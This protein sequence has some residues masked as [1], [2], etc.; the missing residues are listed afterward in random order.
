M[1][2]A[3]AAE[4]VALGL[5][6]K[7]VDKSLFQ[8]SIC[9]LNSLFNIYA[10]T[11]PVPLPA[12]G[13]KITP[14]IRSQ[15]EQYLP[16]SD[17]SSIFNRLYSAALNYPPV[18]SST[19]FH[20]AMSWADVFSALPPQFQFSANP[21]RLLETL[22]DD[23][24]LLTRFMFASFQPGRFYG[25]SSRYPGQHEYIRHWLGTR[26]AVALHC[27]D[28]ACGAG[29]ETYA[30]ALLL[31]ERGYRPENIWI[32]GWTLEPLEVWSAT[33]RRFPHDRLRETALRQATSNL[34][35]KGYNRRIS[36]CCRDILKS[37]PSAHDGVNSG[38]YDLILCNGLLGGPILHEGRE[39][40]LAIRN[41]AGI[42]APDGVLL[43]ADNF[44][45]GWKQKCPQSELRALFEKNGLKTFEAGEGIGGLKPDQ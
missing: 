28:A 16:I 13:L 36:F 31:P 7:T 38:F 20:N 41:L 8:N 11:C 35:Q 18:F 9:R 3:T 12:P 17:I 32:D 23:C 37:A 5:V 40:E 10:G 1:H 21:A 44:H 39:L 25:G 27:L 19:P 2:S 24:D 22:L 33:Y 14:E 4:S 30:L 43:A 26:K 42:L 6:L 15:S 45:G 29:G 34:M